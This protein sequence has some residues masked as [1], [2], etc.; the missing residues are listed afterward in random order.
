MASCYSLRYTRRLV[1]KSKLLQQPWTQ[2]SQ[3]IIGSFFGIRSITLS[4][5]PSTHAGSKYIKLNQVL[6]FLLLHNFELD[7]RS[8]RA[9]SHFRINCLGEL[10]LISSSPF[11]RKPKKMTSYILFSRNGRYSQFY[12][13][14]YPWFMSCSVSSS[15]ILTWMA[16]PLRIQWK[17]SSILD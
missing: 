6:S 17:M 9:T 13:I 1:M 5:L 10:S 16:S 7:L 15:H 3:L 12:F 11:P 4:S 14:V 2:C 8:L